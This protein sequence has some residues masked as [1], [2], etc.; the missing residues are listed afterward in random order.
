MSTSCL[1]DLDPVTPLSAIQQMATPLESRPQ[2]INHGIYTVRTQLARRTY[3]RAR[4]YQ[5]TRFCL[6]SACPFAALQRISFPLSVFTAVAIPTKINSPSP[7]FAN[8]TEFFPSSGNISDCC[9]VEFRGF[10]SIICCGV[11]F[12]PNLSSTDFNELYSGK[13]SRITWIGPSIFPSEVVCLACVVC[14]CLFFCGSNFT[15]T[16]QFFRGISWTNVA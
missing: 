8:S 13:W 15:G 11:V 3:V 10:L 12:Y 1:V 6:L 5:T 7:C 9:L 2:V 4:M 16:Y 14:I